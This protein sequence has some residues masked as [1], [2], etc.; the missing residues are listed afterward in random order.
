M[1][2]LFTVYLA[3]SKNQGNSLTDL[4]VKVTLNFELGEIFW[5]HHRLCLLSIIQVE[6]GSIVLEVITGAMSDPNYI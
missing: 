4:L 2:I 3:L 6:R 1:L 5:T